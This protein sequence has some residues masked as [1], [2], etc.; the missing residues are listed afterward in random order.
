MKKFLKTILLIGAMAA[1]LS[2][3]VTLPA[4]ALVEIDVNKGNIEPM[5]IAITDFLS[6]DAMGQK[7]AGVVAADLKRSGLFAPIDRGAFIEKISNPDVAPRFEDWKVIN[8]QALVTGR[9]TQ[10]ADG[11]LRAEFRLWDT[12]AGQQL[13]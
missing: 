3:A 4:R 6:G 12:F 2:T 9:V 5:P 1:G 13:S 11:R 8:A 7:I 10:E